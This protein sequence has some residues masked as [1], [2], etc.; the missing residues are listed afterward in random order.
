MTRRI[1]F[2]R[3]VNLGG[4]TILM[5]D[6][7]RT[8]ERLGCTR[9]ETFIASGNVIFDSSARAEPALAARIERALESEYGFAVPTLLRTPAEVRSLADHAPFASAAVAKARALYVGL[10]AAPASASAARAVDALATRDESFALHGRELYWLSR[11]GQGESKIDLKKLERALGQPMTMRSVTTLR[12][13][14]DKYPA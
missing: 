6:L 3:A 4:R 14:A 12:K 8:F 7:R 9:V 11:P 2:L 13:L 5:A 1:A 10:L